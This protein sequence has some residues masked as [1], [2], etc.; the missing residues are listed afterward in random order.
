MKEKYEK[1]RVIL[2]QNIKKHRKSLGFSQ[3]KLAEA[4]EMSVQAINTIEGCRMWISDKSISRI[5]RALDV[6]VFQLFVPHHLNK[7]ELSA[8]T[9]SA[10]I[11]LRQKIQS[12]AETFCTVIDN[13]IKDALK[14]PVERHHETDNQKKSNKNKKRVK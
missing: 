5:A 8:A 3:E 7:R 6:E 1:I 9:S 12:D 10:L 11:E 2:A 14:I 4:A 13:R